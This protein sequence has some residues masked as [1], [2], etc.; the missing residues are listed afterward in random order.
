MYKGINMIIS[1]INQKGGTG[2]TTI[3]VNIAREYTKRGAKTLLVDSDNQ[4]SAQRWHEK[5][6]GELIDLTCLAMTTLDKDVLKF[7]NH[8][9]RI[10]IDGTPRVSPI[11]IAAIKAADLI[12]IPVQPSPYDIWATEDLVRDVKHRIEMTDG[13]TK[14]AFIVSRKI[15]GTNIAKDVYEQ[16]SSLELPIFVNGTTQRVSYAT[17]AS[18]GS[19]VIDRD[20]GKND[21]SKEISAIV[22]EIE[23][24]LNGI[25]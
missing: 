21:S 18:M 2:K 15:K 17:S 24:Y 12:L 8:Y 13:K 7:A 3:S 23:E 25:H 10:I 22:D 16:L 9:E 6:G 19:T 20:N 5:S 1:I 14:A 11:T 4:G